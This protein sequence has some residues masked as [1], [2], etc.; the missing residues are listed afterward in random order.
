MQGSGGSGCRRGLGRV[1][2]EDAG[3]FDKLAMGGQQGGSAGWR[4]VNKS[5]R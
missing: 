1:A 2:V 3:R 4:E 5:D